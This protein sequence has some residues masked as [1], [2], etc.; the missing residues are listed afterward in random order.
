MDL[1][2]YSAYLELKSTI[3]NAMWEFTEKY[4]S[5]GEHCIYPH[6]REILIEV[7]TECLNEV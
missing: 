2:E 6:C 1:K 4:A 5:K 3:V 7:L